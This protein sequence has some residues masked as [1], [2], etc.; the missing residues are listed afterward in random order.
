MITIKEIS[1][2][3]KEHQALTNV[4]ISI[5]KGAI[6][7]LIGH[8]GAG[9]TTLIRI[10]TQIIPSDKGTINYNG[11]L[12]APK[13]RYKIGYLPEE[14]GVY[15]KMKV[16]DYLLFLSRLHEIPKV[17]AKSKIDFWLKKFDLFQYSTKEILSLSKGMQQ[18][19][20]FIASVFFDPELLI[21]DEPFSGFDP[22]NV[23]LLKAE[24]LSL[25]NKGVTII[26]STHQME[27]VEEICS[28]V[29]MINQSRIVLSG[30]LKELKKKHGKGKYRLRFSG[31]ITD[32]KSFNPEKED[33]YI[34]VDLKGENSQKEILT[35]LTNFE[36][37]EFQEYKTSLREI[38]LEKISNNHD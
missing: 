12:L 31:D 28:E 36:V 26:F 14:R 20:Q 25:S 21:L 1:K 15:R 3:Y 34:I 18:K 22:A 9:K 8:N 19:V 17:E 37:F 13:H 2:A 27:A 32:L 7:G 16:K 33:D 11:E 10:L 23:E 35:H 5:P 29:C 30:N 6:Y 24:I 38:F 4:S